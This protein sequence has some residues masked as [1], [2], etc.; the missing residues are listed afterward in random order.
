MVKGHMAVGMQGGRCDCAWGGRPRAMAPCPI[1]PG[2]P[3]YARGAW[4]D[5]RAR[6]VV[7]VG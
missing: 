3:T 2:R 1:R 4:S 5:A 7:A 6:G